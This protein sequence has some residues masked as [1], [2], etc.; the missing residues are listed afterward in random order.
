M[1]SCMSVCTMRPRPAKVKEKLIIGRTIPTTMSSLIKLWFSNCLALFIL[2]MEMKKSELTSRIASS[3][4]QKR[5]LREIVFCCTCEGLSWKPAG[6]YIDTI[7][8][9]FSLSLKS[10]YVFV[11]AMVASLLFF[12][13]VRYV[14]TML[15]G[16]MYPN[17]NLLTW[18]NAFNVCSNTIYIKWG[19]H[20]KGRTG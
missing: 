3:P 20:T 15:F 12:V 1:L 2:I 14:H 19:S 6:L 10:H 13:S 11:S 5:N 16:C 17:T 18:S 7:S 8:F 4:R 9:F